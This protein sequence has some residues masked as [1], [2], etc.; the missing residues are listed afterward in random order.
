MI[1]YLS[2]LFSDAMTKEGLPLLFPLNINFGI[3]PFVPL[4]VTTGKWVENLAVYPA[5]WIYLIW[6]ITMNQNSL[7]KILKL[8]S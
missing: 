6:F 1:G 5:V 3:P 7:I 4:R 8:V 2:H